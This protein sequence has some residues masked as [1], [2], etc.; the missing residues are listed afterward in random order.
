MQDT[1]DYIRKR[2]RQARDEAGLTQRELAQQFGCSQVTMSDIERGVTR[3]NAADL[4]RLASIL[5]K[6]VLYFFQG[7][8]Q[9]DLSDDEQTLIALYRDFDEYWQE[10]LLHTV[11]EQLEFYERI[12]AAD[13]V[14]DRAGKTGAGE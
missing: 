11:R 7:V 12:Q 4:P 14:H 6:S 9:S 8:Q 10:N 5:G 3:V 13:S 1:N 2:I